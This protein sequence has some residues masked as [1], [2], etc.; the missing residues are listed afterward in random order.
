MTRK[1]VDEYIQIRLKEQT[2]KSMWCSHGDRAYEPISEKYEECV[3][4][5]KI[6]RIR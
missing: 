5:G 3:H 6:R 4:C 2:R 1:F